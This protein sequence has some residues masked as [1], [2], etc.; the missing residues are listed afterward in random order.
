MMMTIRNFIGVVIATFVV[1]ASH[2]IFHKI[3]IHDL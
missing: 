1:A 2:N 3:R